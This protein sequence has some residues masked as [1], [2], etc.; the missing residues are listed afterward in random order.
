MYFVI[1]ICMFL[2]YKW[3]GYLN[4]FVR[5]LIFSTEMSSCRSPLISDALLHVGCGVGAEYVCHPVS[6]HMLMVAQYETAWVL[7]NGVRW[8]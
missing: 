4:C 8:L 7:S 6:S 1:Y 3:N 5:K 2:F